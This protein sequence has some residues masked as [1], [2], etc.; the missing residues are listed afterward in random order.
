MTGKRT[1]YWMNYE[2]WSGRKITC[3]ECRREWGESMVPQEP[4]KRI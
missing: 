4:P 1:M 3:S 2:V